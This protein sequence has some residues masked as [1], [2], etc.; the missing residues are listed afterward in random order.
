MILLFF[1]IF[2]MENT[3]NAV[4]SG[5]PS[6][7]TDPLQSLPV[8]SSYAGNMNKKLFLRSRQPFQFFKIRHCFLPA[9]TAH[10]FGRLKRTANFRAI[11]RIENLT[12][13]MPV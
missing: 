3:G 7:P 10:L 6:T 4:L 12:A 8:S 1:M 9:M 11:R 5:V 2:S 13:E